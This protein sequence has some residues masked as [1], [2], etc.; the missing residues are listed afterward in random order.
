MREAEVTAEVMTCRETQGS[1]GHNFL[2]PKKSIMALTDLMDQGER[3]RE[4]KEYEINKEYK[5]NDEKNSKKCPIGEQ[6]P[7]SACS[8]NISACS[9]DFG[10]LLLTQPNT[11]MML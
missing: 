1:C 3:S 8:A 2:F 10:I 5:I 9:R 7:F 11:T 4:N 6:A